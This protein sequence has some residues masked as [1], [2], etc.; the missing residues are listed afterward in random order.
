MVRR[1]IRQERS[2]Q[3]SIT[4]TPANLTTELPFAERLAENLKQ[5]CASL[6]IQFSQTTTHGG[7][8][9]REAVWR[10]RSPDRQLESRAILE[11]TGHLTI[12]LWSGDPEM[13][14]V[15]LEAALGPL[16]HEISMRRVSV[17]EIG[18]TLQV[19]RLQRLKDLGD[20]SIEVI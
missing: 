9:P 3:Q 5:L 15:R 19:L 11:T 10:W 14:G 2:G 20:I 8:E 12:Q 6:R 17:S 7:A 16:R 13:E 1:V 18:G 4:S